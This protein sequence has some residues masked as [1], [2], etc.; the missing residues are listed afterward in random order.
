MRTDSPVS[1]GEPWTWYRTSRWPTHSS[2][3]S[4]TLTP[5]PISTTP[6]RPPRAPRTYRTEGPGNTELE[7]VGG[8][9]HGCGYTTRTTADGR[10]DL[11][12]NRDSSP[13]STL[14]P[15]RPTDTRDDLTSSS[16]VPFP[17]DPVH[18]G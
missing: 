13:L 8:T 16:P 9:P 2:S 14:L 4:T 12:F 5:T 7:Y 11:Y 10:R 15:L 17:R 18:R 3:S 1:T 6:V